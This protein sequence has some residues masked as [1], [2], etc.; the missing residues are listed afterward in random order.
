LSDEKAQRFAWLFASADKL[1]TEAQ[2]A[3]YSYFNKIIK[4][5]LLAIFFGELYG[6]F[7]VPMLLAIAIVGALTAMSKYRQIK[8][9]RLEERYLDYRALAEAARVQFFWHLS[10]TPESP[11]DHYLRDQ[12]DELE[13]LRQ[14]IRAM[15]L[16]TGQPI[17]TTD[18]WVGVDI[19]RAA[20][21]EGQLGYFCKKAPVYAGNAKK[22][23][24]R[25]GY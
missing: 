6:L 10:G 3:D 7:A 17:L 9:Q 5:S 23:S 20:W 19:A 4:L 21:V 1:S 8:T 22:F 14:A 12:R 24:R 13:W 11:A 16:P 15:N 2:K 25:A 18:A